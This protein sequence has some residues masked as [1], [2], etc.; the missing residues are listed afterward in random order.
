MRTK[1]HSPC[2]HLVLIFT[3]RVEV[4]FL[5]REN[6]DF[7]TQANTANPARLKLSH[8]GLFNA[9][10]PFLEGF[11]MNKSSLWSQSHYS[12][13]AKGGRVPAVPTSCLKLPSPRYQTRSCLLDCYQSSAKNLQDKEYREDQSTVL[14][15][16]CWLLTNIDWL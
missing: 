1:G 5:I 3:P 2:I 11:E 15:A 13:A 9:S 4:Y 6:R 14:C 10:I 7:I 12:W 16:L 8:S